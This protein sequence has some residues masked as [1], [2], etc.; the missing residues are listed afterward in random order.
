MCVIPLGFL[1]PSSKQEV[2]LATGIKEGRKPL[3][4]ERGVGS[5]LKNLEV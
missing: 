5:G 1:P 3:N 2:V 4:F